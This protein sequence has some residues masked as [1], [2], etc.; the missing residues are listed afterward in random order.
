MKTEIKNLSIVIP[1]FNEEEVLQ[2]TYTE[3]K[4]I[5]SGISNIN[6]YQFVFVNN[7]S[8]DKTLDVLINLK[9]NDNNIK[10][11]DLR[12]NYGYQGSITAGLY[13]VN[14]RRFTR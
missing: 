6:K 13:N 8:T 12:N 10:I 7:G 1:C 4:N 3:L 5:V 14:R 2:H 9:T 11:L